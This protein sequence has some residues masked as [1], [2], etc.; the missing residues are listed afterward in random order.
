MRA[1][2]QEST[3]LFALGAKRLERTTSFIVISIIF[4][5]YINSL[6]CGDGMWLFC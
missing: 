6:F 5:F 2:S 4:S 3:I 1:I